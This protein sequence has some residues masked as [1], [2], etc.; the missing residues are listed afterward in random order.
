[1]SRRRIQVTFP[2]ER[3]DPAALQRV[4]DQLTAEA[5]RFHEL[6]DEVDENGGIDFRMRRQQGELPQ[7]RGEDLRDSIASELASTEGAMI[8]GHDCSHGIDD[9]P[10]E[11]DAVTTGGIRQGARRA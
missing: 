5:A 9:T 10:C 11:I 8:A 3:P 1:M 4:R 7:D 6:V 2:S